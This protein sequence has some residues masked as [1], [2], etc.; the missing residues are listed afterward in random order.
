MT[1]DRSILRG[2]T[3]IYPYVVCV[4]DDDV[5]FKKTD[6]THQVLHV[7]GEYVAKHRLGREFLVELSKKL[8]RGETTLL[9]RGEPDARTYRNIKK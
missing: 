3:W 1:R 4:R 2:I 9:Q 6:S 7:N 5:P 8:D